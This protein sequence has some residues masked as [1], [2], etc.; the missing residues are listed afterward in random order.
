MRY[1]AGRKL[2]AQATKMIKE[3]PWAEVVFSKPKTEEEKQEGKDLKVLMEHCG[4]DEHKHNIEFFFNE[5]LP[6]VE[7]FK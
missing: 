2:F 1:P 6:T 3:T 4:Q 7:E 5:V